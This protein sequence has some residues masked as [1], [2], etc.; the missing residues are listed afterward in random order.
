MRIDGTYHINNLP[1]KNGLEA[2]KETIVKELKVGG[3]NVNVDDIYEKID[4][5]MESLVYDLETIKELSKGSED[6]IT[7]LRQMVEDIVKKQSETIDILKEEN[8]KGK[9]LSKNGPEGKDVINKDLTQAKNTVEIDRVKV[10]E[11]ILAKAKELIGKNGKLGAETSSEK[12]VDFVKE[13]SHGE[14]GKI[15]ILRETIDKS[16]KET[17][18]ILGKLPELSKETYEKVI[19]KLDTFMSLETLKNEPENATMQLEKMVEEMI[20]RNEKETSNLIK[21]STVRDH[22]LKDGVLNLDKKEINSSLNNLIGGSV[23]LDT[24]EM[25]EKVLEFVKVAWGEDKE[26]LDALRVAIDKGF[27]RAEKTLGY[28][29]LTSMKTYENIIAELNSWE[30]ELERRRYPGWPVFNIP[31]NFY[32][33]IMTY[34]RFGI[35]TYI[36]I[37]FAIFILYYGL[38]Y[39]IL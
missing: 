4:L 2:S 32:R 12:V 38:R 10:E 19:K 25:S 21:E 36:T 15:D 34:S 35:R 1:N 37:I 20:S 31:I 18:E 26:K 16:F 33:R 17:E 5:E 30:E 14:K 24:E 3:T 23:R 39:L 7:Q 6:A 8:I 27:N 28:L 11:K 22:S 9:S 29:S 13:T